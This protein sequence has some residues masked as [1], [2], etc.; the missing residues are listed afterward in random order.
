MEEQ[1][2]NVAANGIYRDK[3]EQAIIVLLESLDN[4]TKAEKAASEFTAT[5]LNPDGG[6]ELLTAKLDSVF[7]SETI[8]EDMRPA[9]NL[10]IFH[11]KK[12]MLWGILKLNLNI[13]LNK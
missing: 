1:N 8:D 7:Q 10:L 2:S 6:M 12:I 9:L 11:G 13:C 4:N 5:K 3:K